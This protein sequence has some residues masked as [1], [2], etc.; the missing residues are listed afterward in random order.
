MSTR[1]LPITV[2]GTIQAKPERIVERWPKRKGRRAGVEVLVKWKGMSIENASWED[3]D[4]IKS[5]FPN[6]EGKAFQG[7]QLL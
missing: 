4:D 6:L 7:G 2:E 3:L 5:H 1:L